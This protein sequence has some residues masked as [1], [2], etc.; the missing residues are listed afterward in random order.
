VLPLQFL[1]QQV[2]SITVEGTLLH[3]VLAYDAGEILTIVKGE[4]E[5]RVSEEKRMLPGTVDLRHMEMRVFDYADNLS[6]IKATA[7]LSA[8]E[9]YVLD[10]LTPSGARFAR[11]VRERVQGLRKEEAQRIIN[12]FPEVEKAE[13]DLWPPWGTL[14]PSIPSSIAIIAM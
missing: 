6:W 13:I 14:L 10:P 12:N 8:T 2:S 1:N 11:K 7:E 4:L 5:E 9:Q 3:R